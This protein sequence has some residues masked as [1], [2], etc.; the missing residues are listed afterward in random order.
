MVLQDSRSRSILTLCRV[1]DTTETTVEIET[2][3]ATGSAIGREVLAVMANGT[4]IENEDA[5]GH[6]TAGREEITIPM[7]TQTVVI[8]GIVNERT[9]MP[10]ADETT[11]EVVTGAVTEDHHAETTLVVQGRLATSLMIVGVVVA[12]PIETSSVV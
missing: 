5:A 10:A 12:G 9:A 4:E 11:T 2:E 1:R 7:H 3:T 6:H 8:T